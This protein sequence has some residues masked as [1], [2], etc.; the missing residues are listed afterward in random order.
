MVCELKEHFNEI[1][2]RENRIVTTVLGGIKRFS[3]AVIYYVRKSVLFGVRNKKSLLDLGVQH[4][5]LDEMR[6]FRRLM[7]PFK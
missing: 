7:S 6:H 3:C 5:S 4:K 2:L 1:M